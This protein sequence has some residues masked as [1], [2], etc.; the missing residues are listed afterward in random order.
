MIY[1]YSDYLNEGKRGESVLYWDNSLDKLM[2]MDW[3]NISTVRFTSNKY[4]LKFECGEDKYNKYTVLIDTNDLVYVEN[5]EKFVQKFKKE[6]WENPTEYV[7][8]FKYAPKFLGDL[9]GFRNANKY[10]L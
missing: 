8:K 5:P 4:Y 1:K 6:F 2:N 10:N 9:G 7:H 3:K